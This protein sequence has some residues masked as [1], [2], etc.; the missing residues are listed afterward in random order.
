MFFGLEYGIVP[1]ILRQLT[2]LNVRWLVE[3]G[4]FRTILI[5]SDVWKGIGWGSIIYLA[6][7]TSIDPSLYEAAIIDGAKKIQLLV[8]IT[9]PMLVPLIITMFIL[10]IG[11]VLDAGFEQIFIMRNSSVGRSTEIIDTYSYTVGFVEGNY[12]FGTAVGLFKSTI[13]MALVL[14]AN[15]LSRKYGEGSLI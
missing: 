14:S 11:N 15:H 10:R 2:G 12:A 7:L 9:L 6:A 1:Q 8:Y 5:L 4:P 3:A 13:G